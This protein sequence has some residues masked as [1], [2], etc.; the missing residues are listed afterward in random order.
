MFF[1][2][3]LILIIVKYH[4]VCAELYVYV[5][6]YVY[7][8]MYVRVDVLCVCVSTHASIKPLISLP[9]SG[10][11]FGVFR[12]ARRGGMVVYTNV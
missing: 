11:G 1:Y 6:E 4:F 10:L 12:V 2:I 9:L 7:M 5:Y 8:Y 3:D